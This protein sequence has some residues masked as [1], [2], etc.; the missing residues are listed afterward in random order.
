MQTNA[1]EPLTMASSSLFYI[2]G[3]LTEKASSLKKI[4]L[5]VLNIPILSWGTPKN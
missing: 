1:T 2:V 4:W 5:F 3:W